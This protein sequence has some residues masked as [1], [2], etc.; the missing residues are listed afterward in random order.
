MAHA[1]MLGMTA[2]KTET[3]WAMWART[4]VAMAERGELTAAGRP[5]S[6]ETLRAIA[7]GAETPRIRERA[8]L[9]LADRRYP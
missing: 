4:M 9:V 5:V 6:A 1:P 2:H 3:G 7:E 8:L